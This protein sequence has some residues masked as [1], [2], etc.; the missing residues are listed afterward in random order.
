MQSKVLF[1][2]CLLLAGQIGLGSVIADS[3]RDEIK[4]RIKRHNTVAKDY[5]ECRELEDR[6][7]LHRQM[8][9]DY[10]MGYDQ[11]TVQQGE[12]Y[13]SWKVAE[14]ADY[15]SPYFTNYQTIPLTS[16]E[17]IAMSA[18]IEANA[19]RVRFPDWGPV[20]FMSW[21]SD[22]GFVMRTKFEGTDRCTGNT[23]SFYTH[24]FVETNENGE[25]THWETWPDTPQYDPFLKAAI[26]QCGPW[27]DAQE[28]Y[29]AIIAFLNK[30][31][32]GEFSCPVSE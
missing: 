29:G 2:I 15:W 19:Y 17:D 21:P 11:E 31:E 1:I 18:T 8:A 26:G 25:L 3:P 28:Y 22:H 12:A 16:M 14:G 30:A 6:I 20:E 5:F 13:A 23:M 7:E 24:G 27:K 4:D 10:Y 9:E 32:A